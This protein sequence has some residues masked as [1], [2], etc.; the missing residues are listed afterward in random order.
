VVRGKA[1]AGEGGG[2]VLRL[3]RPE[4]CEELVDLV[5]EVVDGAGFAVA[6]EGEG[7]DGAAAGG[8]AEAEVDAVGVEGVERAEGFGDLEG[9][10]VREHDAAGADAD[11]GGLSADAGEEDLRGGAGEQAHGVVLGHPEAREAE[12]FDVFREGDGVLDGLGGGEAGGDGGLI[13]YGEAEIAH[14]G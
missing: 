1:V 10:V 7:L 5:S 9:A 2:N 8:A 3:I 13:E 12:C 14:G 4:P 6:L 11:T